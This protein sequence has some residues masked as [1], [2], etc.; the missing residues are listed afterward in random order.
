MILERKY[1]SKKKYNRV[2]IESSRR[3]RHQIHEG[4]RDY[5]FSAGMKHHQ[6]SENNV[7]IE[8]IQPIEKIVRSAMAPGRKCSCKRKDEPLEV[9]TYHN[10]DRSRSPY[11]PKSYRR[12]WRMPLHTDDTPKIGYNCKSN[13]KPSNLSI[14]CSDSEYR[15]TPKVSHRM[16]GSSTVVSSNIR[17]FSADYS[18]IQTPSEFESDDE[19]PVTLISVL[20][21]LSTFVDLLGSLG[22]QMIQLMTDAIAREKLGV[23]FSDC[24]LDDDSRGI[25]FDAAKEKLNGLLKANL[26]EL[27]KRQEID[28]IVKKMDILITEANKRKRSKRFHDFDYINRPEC[29]QTTNAA[30][31]SKPK[32]EDIGFKYKSH[33]QVVKSETVFDANASVRQECLS[34]LSEPTTLNNS[35]LATLIQNF[36]VLSDT[37]K[38]H[39]ITRIRDIEISDPERMKC[40]RSEMQIDKLLVFGLRKVEVKSEIVD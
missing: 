29:P 37:E 3:N 1:R 10:R 25:V 17:G 21:S 11:E 5:R 12:N 28:Q 32:M 30:H 40:L 19:Q 13:R 7:K 8:K 38:Y 9:S 15:F 36:H 23:K 22:P 20:N 31:L 18:P 24:L 2:P 16:A 33:D 26:V 4:R 35:N 39:V 14:G 34:E 6:H 27:N